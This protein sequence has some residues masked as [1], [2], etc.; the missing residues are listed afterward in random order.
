MEPD[1]R[2]WLTKSRRELV[3]YRHSVQLETVQKGEGL[4]KMAGFALLL[5]LLASCASNSNGKNFDFHWFPMSF[6]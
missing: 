2:Y 5:F 1:E 3:K 4:A 6:K